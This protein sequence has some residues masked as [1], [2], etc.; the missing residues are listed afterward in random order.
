MDGLYEKLLRHGREGSYPFHMPGHKRNP[1]WSFENPYAWDITEIDGFDDLHHP[2]G[3]LKEAMEEA[4]CI[5]G[6]AHSFFLVNGSSCGLLAALQAAVRPGE[7]LLVARNCHK[8]VY[9]SALQGQLQ[10]TY[11]YPQRV[12]DWGINGSISPEDVENL[13]KKEPDI[14]VVVIT[15]PTYEGIVSDVAQIARAV[16]AHGAALIVD[17]AHGA[18]FSF[19]GGFPASAVQLG[20]DIVVQSLHKTLPSLTQTAILHIGKNSRI[21]AEWVQKYLSIYESSSPSYVL[22]ASIDRCVRYMNGEGRQQLSAFRQQLL[23][24]R[25]QLAGHIRLLDP[26]PC[27]EV[28]AYDE[29][30][31]FFHCPGKGEWMAEKLRKEYS[32]ES[33]KADGDSVLLMT[34]LMDQ[35]EG[36][37]RLL[38]AA[39]QIGSALQ[40]STP[41]ALWAGNLAGEA[42]CT[43]A[44]AFHSLQEP[45]PLWE[46]EGRVSGEFVY[47]YPP[48]IPVLAPGERITKACLSYLKEQKEKGA[49]IK[50]M[51]DKDSENLLVLC[52]ER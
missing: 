42:V 8:S 5:Y 50:G 49:R 11:V 1:A 13:L 29:S 48:G 25:K 44:E 41:V 35:K 22:L 45:T 51:A 40:K 43:L 7:K 16:H 4:A 27:K 24:Y 34:S 28:F 39:E 47:L 17:E 19:G 46:S 21:S 30:K 37:D 12:D 14:R 18:H 33:E 15:S 9:H 31:L 23:S 32:L 3:I 36:L 38:K 10:V 6:A 20:A 26:A 52:R 2:E